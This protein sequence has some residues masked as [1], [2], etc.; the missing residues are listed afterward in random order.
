MRWASPLDPSFY[1]YITFQSEAWEKYNIRHSYVTGWPSLISHIFT[2]G[3]SIQT[4]PNYSAYFYPITH[5][6]KKLYLDCKLVVLTWVSLV[7]FQF[8]FESWTHFTMTRAQKTF[9]V[10]FALWIQK[11]SFFWR[12]RFFFISSNYR[13]STDLRLNV[14][15]NA[16]WHYTPLASYSHRESG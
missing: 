3:N 15:E 10:N 4:C 12:V 14:G 8:I 6:T 5:T 7:S 2:L 9:S 13:H 16:S 11:E 1:I